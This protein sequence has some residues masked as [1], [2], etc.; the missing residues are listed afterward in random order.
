MHQVGPSDGRPN[1][2]TNAACFGCTIAC[3]R[4]S[5]IDRGHF[6]IEHKPE[7]W[8]AWA[9]GSDTGI[10]D[11]DAL[12]YANFLCNEDG[13]DPI[14]FGSTGHRHGAVR[15]WVE[16][17]GPN[18]IMEAYLATTQAVGFNAEILKSAH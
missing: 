17:Q 18:R 5:T 12:T 3:G 9:L 7:Y 2:V 1:L 4:I 11:L 15:A 10:D 13:F 16:M 14:S 6:T 8:A